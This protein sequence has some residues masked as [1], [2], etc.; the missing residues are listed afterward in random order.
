VLHLPETGLSELTQVNAKHLSPETLIGGAEL[1]GT[2]PLWTWIG[3][4]A[5]TTFSY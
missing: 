1:Q 2:V 5:T 4:E 3:D